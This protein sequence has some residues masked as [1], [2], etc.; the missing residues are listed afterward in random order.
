[1]AM[2]HAPRF[3]RL[4]TW[5]LRFGAVALILL[6]AAVPAA[7]VGLPRLARSDWALAKV[8]A[9]LSRAARAPVRA[10][11]IEF[12]WKDGLRLLDLSIAAAAC[13]PVDVSLQAPEARI[14][15]RRR[16][17]VTVFSPR[18]R[19]VARPEAGGRP[20]ASYRLDRLE[21]RD[22]TVEIEDP[23]HA[24]SLLLQGVNGR[25]SIAEGKSGLA[26]SLR[27]L[28]CT[29]NG[30]K[31]EGGLTLRSS[32]RSCSIQADLKGE[33]I[34]LN[35]FLARFARAAAPVLESGSRGDSYGRLS[36]ELRGNGTGS[37]A[38][39]LLSRARAD[40]SLSIRDAALAA[41]RATPGRV[42]R[43]IDGAFS[44][45]EGRLLNPSLDVRF[46][47]GEPWRLMGWT[48]CT[49]RIDY[50]VRPASGAPFSI[51]GTL[52]APRIE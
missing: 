17:T 23:S 52:D 41:G 29:A 35:G 22:A 50:A 51:S 1:M 19:V 16:P 9:S 31:L 40:G 4:L 30:G 18:V 39:E 27:R 15:L 3:R 7:Y 11:R 13:G 47:S 33:D 38:R 24:G 46:A 14:P 10:T 32:S 34:A 42:V 49:G 45:F 43:E 6:V 28:S 36:F 48:S 44:L 21:L 8:E 20:K 37:G 5:T 2:P 25:L 12:C 26:V